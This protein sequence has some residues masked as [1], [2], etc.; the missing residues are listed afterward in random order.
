M[1][2]KKLI[3]KGFGAL[4]NREY[5]FRP[6]WTEIP[7]PEE[8]GEETVNEVIM[9]LLFGFSP[10]QRL[11]KERFIP[12]RGKDE[13]QAA[14]MVET[15]EGQYLLGRHFAQETLEIFKLEDKRLS[16]LSPMVLM[17]LLYKEMGILN[18]LDFQV[19]AFYQKE[20]LLLDQNAPLVRD[21]TRQIRLYEDFT[22]LLMVSTDG[23]E[24]QQ[25]KM[26]AERVDIDGLIAEL[27]RYQA[28]VERIKA[29]EAHYRDY[30]KFLS[31]EGEDLLALTAREYTAVALEKSFY[32]EQ[33]REEVETR[34]ILETEVATLRQKIASFDPFLYTAETEQKV[35]RLL[36]YR[37]EL[38][39]RLQRE[40]EALEQ[41]SRK[42]Y[43]HRLGSKE[44]EAEIKQ[45]MGRILEDL[46]RL[47]AELRFLLK[48]KKPEDFLKEKTLLE[49]YQND[50]SRL[51]TPALFKGKDQYSLEELDRIRQREEELRQKREK[52]LAL[53]GTEDIET[54]QENVKA[55]ADWK[56]RRRQAE[57]ELAAFLKKVGGAT[58]EDARRLLLAKREQQEE[59][60][61]TEETKAQVLVSGEAS[62]LAKVYRDAGRYLSALTAGD[63]QSIKPR[64]EGNTLHFM[65]GS[66][67][68]WCTEEAVFPR[69]PW[70]HLAFR[71][72]LAKS[73]WEKGKSRP[74]LLFDDFF[75]WLMP[76]A[77]QALR[78]L[79]AE[80]FADGQI[81][82]RVREL[83]YSTH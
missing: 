57:E 42:S 70:A 68:D 41:F 27:D 7:F 52:L 44:K 72:A 61:K 15:G 10:P 40:E 71:L 19:I 62:T 31:P 16:S 77:E 14:M 11:K 38:N 60:L 23:E 32:E 78:Q 24:E 58:P 13:Y 29:E 66:G 64:L 3:V 79:L 33:L 63:Y 8:E 36:K 55:L 39:Q 28:E 25:Q 53:A 46:A 74:L 48:N 83:A 47:R 4:R 35:I 51:E 73:V 34:R 9:A 54:V 56:A 30:E 21:H 69:R 81:I 76:K 75:P 20:K 50:L 82:S 18:P 6:F 45:R 2:I 22:E 1:R 17:D 67:T 43:W 26:A 80:D 49:Q 65:V 5:D 12:V 37:A 59:Q